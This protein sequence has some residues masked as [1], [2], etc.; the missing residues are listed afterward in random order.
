MNNSNSNVVSAVSQAKAA[1]EA[2]KLSDYPAMAAAGA[3]P[4]TAT[5]ATSWGPQMRK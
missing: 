2:G 5:I 3:G 4:V 1:Y